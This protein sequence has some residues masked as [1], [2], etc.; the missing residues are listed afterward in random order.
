MICK[1]KKKKVGTAFYQIGWE[2]NQ[3]FQISFFILKHSQ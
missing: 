1:Q 2:K 3:L